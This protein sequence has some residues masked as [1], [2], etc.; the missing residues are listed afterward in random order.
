MALDTYNNLKT[1][2]ANNLNVSTADISTVIDDAITIVNRRVG[3]ECRTRY[4][5][6]AISLTLSGSVYALPSDYLDL[7]YAYY[8]DT[9][10]REFKLDIRD[11]EELRD[12][13]PDPNNTGDPLYIATEGTNFIVRPKPTVNTHML[14]GRYWQNPLT[15]SASASLNTMFN[16][17]P[18]LYLYGTM[19]EMESRLGRDERIQIWEARYQQFKK[20]INGENN[21]GSGRARSHYL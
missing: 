2:V 8:V 21:Q 12:L 10:G 9:S 18:E 19:A 20:D 4:M 6:G 5:E 1:A 3:R 15:L 17:Y 14:K 11:P 7:K 13:Y 16:N